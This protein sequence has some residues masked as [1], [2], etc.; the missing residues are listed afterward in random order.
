MFDA[1]IKGAVQAAASNGGNVKEYQ[2]NWRGL[3]DAIADG[4]SGGG[5]EI[6]LDGYAT[7]QWV[8]NQ[9]FL[10]LAD[11]ED[12]GDITVDLTG[13]AT[14][15]WVLDKNYI[16]IDDVPDINLD[17]YATE[18]WVEAKGYITAA[19]VPDVDL[20][21]YATEKWVLDRGYITAAEVPD[22]DL[23]GYAT[24]AWV[25][26]RGFVTASGAV[27]A[28][29][30]AGYAT[31]AWV[32]SQGFLK[33]TEGGDIDLSGYATE[34]W[35]LEKNYATQSWV[36]S[37]G[38]ITLGDVPSVD[39]TGYATETWVENKGYI[40]AADVPDVNLDGYAT[41]EWVQE[42]GYLTEH[43]SLDGYATEDWVQSQDYVKSTDLPETSKPE[44]PSAG[45][46]P[47]DPEAGN[48]W[49]NPEDGRLYI[50]YE[51]DNSSQW[52]D[53]SPDTGAIDLSDYA[54]EQWV[55]NQNYLKIEDIDGDGTIDID[56]YATEQWVLDKGYLEKTGGDMTGDL[57]LG[58]N[59]ITLAA[60]DGDA[61]FSGKVGIGTSSP[62]ASLHLST[63]GTDG[64]CLGVD[65][66]SYYHILRPNGDGLYLGADDGNTGGVGADIRFNVKGSE[67]M[68]IDQLGRVGIGAINPNYKVV[69]EGENNA[70]MIRE[71]TGAIDGMSNDTGQ[72]VWFQGGNAEL[73]L[74]KDEDGNYEY[75][76]GTWQSAA[77]IPL[78]FRTESRVERMRITK[79]GNVGIGTNAP[80]T[81]LHVEA[82]HAKQT[83]KSTNT[84]TGSQLIFDNTNITTEDF[85]LGQMTG[86]WQGTD[87]AA[88]SFEAGSDT[89]NKDDGLISF[90]T[91][92]ASGAPT[93]R[94]RITSNGT[95]ELS[96]NSPG[97][98]FGS[99]PSSSPSGREISSMQLDDYEEGTFTPALI[100]NSGTAPTYT[101][102]SNYSSYTKIGSLVTFSA[103]IVVD[104]SDVGSGSGLAITLPFAPTTTEGRQVYSGGP[105]GRASSGFIAAAYEISWYYYP[106]GARLY[107][108]S[109]N[110]VEEVLTTS[111][112]N[113][114]G[115]KRFNI[116][117]FYYTDKQPAM[118]KNY[119]H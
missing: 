34:V 48:L 107:Y 38:Y 14:E 39:L 17:G 47:S 76:L 25:V 77:D 45:A 12:S 81:P 88:I 84:N 5:G 103:D 37:K 51:D 60:S 41:E 114:N 117:G 113:G 93:E 118:A 65:S 68:R 16:T 82:G 43:Q 3:V 24:E 63:T 80:L 21:G 85:L 26:S 102:S 44:I 58:T 69:V 40:T 78:V 11:L 27:E 109:A 90:A 29:E 53:A 50:Y 111:S 6:D 66:Q 94:M 112:I 4:G 2:Y 67:K 101:I 18:A 87:V 105:Q 99:I 64:L 59:K 46:P 92:S 70:L 15:Q 35:V 56:G 72:R 97:I 104:L 106:D 23:D 31:E 89:A 7:E 83:L 95:V 57:T 119:N 61:T 36:E 28:V 33:S 116:G 30:A 49:F 74:F 115:F 86:R 9:N 54:T 96:E 42:Q 20:G 73:G 52:V 71:G 100:V 108:Q 22:V 91:S 10:T 62:A 75:V 79:A 32:N 13:Y 98:Q 55:K 8:L 19:D 1:S 110:G